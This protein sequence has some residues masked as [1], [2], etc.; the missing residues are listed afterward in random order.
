MRQDIEAMI[1]IILFLC[2][3]GVIVAFIIS[4]HKER[5]AMLEKG[6]KGE[7]IK[8]LYTKD[9]HWSPLSSLKWGILFV[10]AGLAVLAGYQLHRTINFDE[11]VTFGGLVP[12]FLGIG[13]L[14][15]YSLASKKHKEE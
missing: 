10:M 3:T 7:E 13:L 12:L 5:M 11:G 4:R 8:A 9:Y 1:P 14:M 15:F 6:L 2:A